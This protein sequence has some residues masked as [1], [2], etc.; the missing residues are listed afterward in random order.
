MQQA[1]GMQKRMQGRSHKFP[2]QRELEREWWTWKYN[3]KEDNKRL[4]YGEVYSMNMTL[5]GTRRRVFALSD[6]KRLKYRWIGRH[7]VESPKSQQYLTNE[8][9]YH[10]LC[11]PKVHYRVHKSSQMNHNLSQTHQRYDKNTLGLPSVFIQGAAERSPLFGK[12]INSKPK[13]IRQIFFYFWKVHRMPFYINVFWT[14][15]RSSGELEYWHTDVVSLGSCP[16]PWESF[17]V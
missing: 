16:W 10:L 5:I 15:H 12:L 4:G 3:T 13:K 2:C 14:K 9:F 6:D 7:S 11:K 8:T 17:Q 1:Y